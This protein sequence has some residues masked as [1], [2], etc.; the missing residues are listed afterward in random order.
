MEEEKIQNNNND[1][2]QNK[3]QT[4][5]WSGVIVILLIL[6]I[7]AIYMGRYLMKT[8]QERKAQNQAIEQSAQKENLNQ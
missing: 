8:A 6:I 5:A 7:G 4:G 1:V 3:N 2:N